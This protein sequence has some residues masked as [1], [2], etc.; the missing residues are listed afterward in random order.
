LKKI[1]DP[2]ITEELRAEFENEVRMLRKLRHPHVV[3]L[4]AVCRKPPA[5]S[6]LTEFVA[7]G[8]L[9][10][11]LHGPPAP[12]HRRHVIP[13]CEL[14]VLFPFM[15]EMAAALNYMHAMLVVHRDVKSQNVLL[16]EGRRPIAKLCDFGL[17]RM[18]S[19]LCTGTMQWAGT[20]TYMA[21]ELF[22][23]KRYTETVDVFAFGVM[24]WEVASL[25]IPHANL[26]PEDIAHRI[27]QKDGAGLPVKH[28]W[29]KPLKALLKT[30]MAVLPMPVTSLIPRSTGPSGV[31]R[32]KL[33]YCLFV[34][35]L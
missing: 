8:S 18:K 17:A 33:W 6:I 5:L 22:E 31:S 14:P 28:D 35:D 3:T 23:K 11:L 20:P 1:F 32:M 15:R 29:P 30:S 26:D 2:V 34:F 24:L 19:E 4:M 16:T 12:A 7:G 21:P 25:E 9:F 13:E 27:R 10:E